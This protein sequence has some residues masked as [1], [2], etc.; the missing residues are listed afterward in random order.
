[1]SRSVK[2]GAAVV[3]RSCQTLGLF[4][5][6]I[7]LEVHFRQHRVFA[8]CVQ[9]PSSPN[10]GGGFAT[11]YPGGSF[12]GLSFAALVELGTGRHKIAECN[13]RDF[14]N[15][16]RPSELQSEGAAMLEWFEEVLFG[17][18]HGAFTSLEVLSAA[19]RVLAKW[20][21]PDTSGD[22]NQSREA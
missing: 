17:Y 19:E 20:N 10:S 21:N 6:T 4:V 16:G 14:Q 12:M 5:H 9:S 2:S 7:T 18:Q 15:T 22:Q 11:V 3:C 8:H 13:E 1:M